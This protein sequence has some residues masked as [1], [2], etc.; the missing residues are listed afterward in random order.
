MSSPALE[1]F[2]ARL[3]TDE[4]ALEAFL[5]G[6]VETARAAA[7]DPA[8]VSALA[9]ADHI[10]LGMAAASFRAKR[11]RLNRRNWLLRWRKYAIRAVR[12]RRMA[13]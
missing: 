6:P 11:E 8:E 10:G 5:R 12:H 2:L 1:H 7:L 3:Y 13:G 4:T 9:G